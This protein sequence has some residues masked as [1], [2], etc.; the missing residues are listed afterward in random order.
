VLPYRLFNVDNLLK[1][2]E[3]RDDRADLVTGDSKELDIF[4]EDSSDSSVP[5]TVLQAFDASGL[6]GT[7][8]AD[9]FVVRV[10]AFKTFIARSRFQEVLSCYFE[11]IPRI[12]PSPRASEQ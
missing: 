9:H 8:P 4:M 1:I 10:K 2:E 6:G 11:I 5:P 3:Y 7:Q 12:F